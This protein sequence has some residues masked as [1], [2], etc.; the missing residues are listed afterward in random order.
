MGCSAGEPAVPA[1]E[2]TAAIERALPV[3]S[4]DTLA[5][6]EV[7]ALQRALERSPLPALE[8]LVEAQVAILAGKPGGRLVSEEGAWVDLPENPGEGILRFANFVNAPFGQPRDRAAEWV[9]ELIRGEESAYVL[10]HQFLVIE[11]SRE[12][13]LPLGPEALGRRRELLARIEE[14]QTKS[15]GFSDLDAE[16]ALILLQFGTPPPGAARAWILRILAAQAPDGAWLQREASNIAFDG[17]ESFTQHTRA[18]T[19]GHAVAALLV[20]LAEFE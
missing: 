4:Q 7:W 11:W 19:T 13:E 17:M 16:R 6:G 15:M 12:L 8:S 18:H 14:E 2:I 9:L 3:L 10:T 1:S 5:L 20:Y